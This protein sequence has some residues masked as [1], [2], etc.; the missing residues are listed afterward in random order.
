MDALEFSELHHS[1]VR[2]GQCA[3]SCYDDTTAFHEDESW[4]TAKRLGSAPRFRRWPRWAGWEPSA[5]DPLRSRTSCTSR[6]DWAW[7]A[8]RL[9]T[10]PDVDSIGIV[11]IPDEERSSLRA[12]RPATKAAALAPGRVAQG[13]LPSVGALDCRPLPSSPVAR[14]ESACKIPARRGADASS[15]GGLPRLSAAR[16]PAQADPARDARTLKS[17]V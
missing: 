9:A 3:P 4:A 1:L 17:A 11:R 13:G 8:L 5:R 10:V 14:R 2:R 16:I 7:E 12:L 6:A 15:R